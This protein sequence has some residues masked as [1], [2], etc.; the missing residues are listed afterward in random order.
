MFQYVIA[1]LVFGSIYALSASGLVV[2]YLS[3]GILNFSFGAIAF[4][5]ARLYYE[6][7][8]EHGWGVFPAFLVSV[9]V[10]APLIGLF[11]Y[12][13]LFRFI[14]LSSTLVKIVVTIGVAVTI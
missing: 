9:F 14:Q 13:V 10:A 4:A 7:N 3:A 2:T 11:L 8:T 1:G 12:V 6:L 5:V